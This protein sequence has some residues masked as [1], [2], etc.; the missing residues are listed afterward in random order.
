MTKLENLIAELCPEGVEWKRLGDIG[1]FAC[2][3]ANTAKSLNII[4]VEIKGEKA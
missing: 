2:G 1:T 3:F 4:F